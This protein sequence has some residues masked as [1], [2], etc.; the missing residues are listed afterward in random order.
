MKVRLADLHVTIHALRSLVFQT[1]GSFAAGQA[2]EG[3]REGATVL[4]QDGNR[5]LV[6][7]VSRDGKRIYRTLEEVHFFPPERITFRHL[8]GPLHHASEEFQLAEVAEGTRITY[9]GQIECR[10]P[11]LPGAGWLVA[12]WY[13]RPRYERLV[14]RH[15]G[16]LK[17]AVEGA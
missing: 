17:E 8:K 13:V 6:Q 1:F 4:E 2:P 3:N 15:M 11:W 10:M 9:R 16:Q 12:R 5:L 7:F 14:S